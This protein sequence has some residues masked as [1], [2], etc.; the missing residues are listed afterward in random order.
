MEKDSWWGLVEITP[1]VSC[2]KKLMSESIQ[3]ENPLESPTNREE[4][5]CGYGLTRPQCSALVPLCITLAA[6]IYRIFRLRQFRTTNKDSL[7]LSLSLIFFRPRTPSP[8]PAVFIFQSR[9]LCVRRRLQSHFQRTQGLQIEMKLREICL[10]RE[11]KYHLCRVS[12]QAPN[13]S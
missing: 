3:K 13:T 2:R 10:V 5:H 11:C 9:R 7:H 8:L 12:A 6:P 4:T 1:G